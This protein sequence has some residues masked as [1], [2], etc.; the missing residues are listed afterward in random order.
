MC[1]RLRWSVSQQNERKSIYFNQYVSLVGRIHYRPHVSKVAF[2]TSLHLSF[3]PSL[4]VRDVLS[5]ENILF[6]ST[7]VNP[8]SIL[9]HSMIFIRR[10]RFSRE[11]GFSVV[12]PTSLYDLLHKDV[13]FLVA[14]CWTASSFV[15]SFAW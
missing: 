12:V 11:N 4:L 15:I 5:I 10:R 6:A 9:K 1:K 2:W 3:T 7:F 13:I 8:L 14:L